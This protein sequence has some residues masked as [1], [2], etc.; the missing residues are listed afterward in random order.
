MENDNLQ[1]HLLS[2]NTRNEADMGPHKTVQVMDPLQAYQN[3]V[4]GWTNA[5]VKPSPYL[6]QFELKKA[7]YMPGKQF[8]KTARH[9]DN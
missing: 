4:F 5:W 3:G 8:S 2:E 7:K 9:T 1:S 6:D